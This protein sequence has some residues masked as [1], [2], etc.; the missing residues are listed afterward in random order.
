MT[1]KGVMTI[2]FL[3]FAIMNAS[4]I[5][6]A[7]SQRVYIIGGEGQNPARF[8]R[9]VEIFDTKQKS[10]SDGPDLST[11]RANLGAAKL[12]SF[13]YAIGGWKAPTGDT[14]YGYRANWQGSERLSLNQSQPAAWE[15]ARPLPTSRVLL[16]VAASTMKLFA[17]GRH[18]WNTERSFLEALDEQ[19]QN[20]SSRRGMLTLRNG[21]VTGLIGDFLYAVGGISGDSLFNL[22]E[23]YKTS[24]DEWSTAAP[25]QIARAY[26]CAAVLDGKLFVIGGTNG[27][28]A[29]SS[30]EIYNPASD[31]WSHIAN[32]SARR[33][34]C[35]A[36]G[37]DGLIYVFGG[38]DGANLLDSVEV[39][40]ATSDSWQTLGAKMKIARSRFGLAVV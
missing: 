15:E 19:T 14:A 28:L 21:F 4:H 36:A 35:G 32:M 8:L 29:L 16:G 40:N 23:R 26:A 7:S 39:Y 34:L 17:V 5:E 25:M 11:W 13:V 33:S 6:R 22:T 3:I 9:S 20:W 12:G 37:V 31:K 18:N 2:L 38:Q 10:F 1:S 24:T 27:T 30:A